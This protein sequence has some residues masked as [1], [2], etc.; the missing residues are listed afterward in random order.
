MRLRGKLLTLLIPLVGSAMVALGSLAYLQLRDAAERA[1][2]QQVE[3]LLD[4]VARQV[5]AVIGAAQANAQLFASEYLLEKY[6]LAEDEA[7]RYRLLQRPLLRAFARYQKAY[8][9]YYEIR[10]V[11]PDGY[12]SARR[13]IGGTLGAGGAGEHDPWIRALEDAGD[14]VQTRVRINPDNGEVAVY[15]GKPVRLRQITEDPTRARPVLR[16]YLVITMRL[17]ELERQLDGRPFGES[18]LLFA[19]DDA[20]R[21]LFDAGGRPALPSDGDRTRLREAIGAVDLVSLDWLDGPVYLLGRAVTPGLVLYAALPRATVQATTTRLGH[22]VV[23]ATVLT[24]LLVSGV[25]F[26][27]LRRLVLRPL[28]RLEGLAG[29]IG[30]GRL[31]VEIV[32]TGDDEMASLER[33]FARMAQ[34][35]AASN[36]RVR[37]LADHDSLTGLPNRRLFQEFLHRALAHSRRAEEK[38]GL[39]FLDMDEFKNVNDTLGHHAGD[40]LLERFAERLVGVLRAQDLVAHR[41]D[42]PGHLVARLG[43]DEFIILLSGVRSPTDA[44]TVAERILDRLRDPFVINRQRFFIGASIGITVFPDDGDT[45]ADLVK[46]ADLAMYHAKRAGKNTYQFYSADM[47]VAAVHRMQTERRLRRALERDEFVLHFQPIVDLRT[48]VVVGAEA[49]LRWQDPETGDLVPPDEFIPVAEACGL[50]L[51]IGDWVLESATAIARGWPSHGPAPL[52]V[53]VNVSAL[54]V[55]QGGLAAR[56]AATLEQ[57]GLEPS[58]LEVELTETVIMSSVATVQAELDQLKALGVTVALDDFG[59]GYSSLG[60][61]RRFSIDTLKIDRSFV[62]GCM[63]QPSQ[64]GIVSAV[65][66][67]AQALELRIVAEG[68]ESDD[69]RAFLCAE[70]CNLGQGYLFSRP[71]PAAEFERLLATGERAGA[72][73]RSGA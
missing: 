55:E 15:V 24:I 44:A 13:V 3:T 51:P 53:C 66:A 54:Q 12:A 70:G 29:A 17:A 52:R 43:G 25:L 28:Q 30:E 61:L 21:L 2:L 31:D 56:V 39:L 62:A 16:G 7:E 65:I 11:L 60:Y 69:E 37:F 14:G 23:A 33:S 20:S 73:V 57:T 59:I 42:G 48:G 9:D 50:I 67:M 22:I 71:L 27:A 5:R 49:L 8:P 36:D 34:S 63:S 41:N 64:R 26:A 4:Q 58:R 38:L 47:N 46:H 18:G 40:Q 68:I 35:L 45:V 6:A 1:Q 32:S 10:F 72:R 19:T